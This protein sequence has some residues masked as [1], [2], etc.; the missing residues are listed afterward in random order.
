MNKGKA[1]RISARLRAGRTAHP[2][3][4]LG[5]LLVKA[6][7]VSAADRDAA[8]KIQ[9]SAH[10]VI[11]QIFIDMRACSLADISRALAAQETVP[12]ID[13]ENI[14]I[15]E[16]ALA[17]LPR[18]VCENLQ[19]LPFQKIDTL[20]C[21]A[22]TGKRHLRVRSKLQDYTDCR[23]KLYECGTGQIDEFIRRYYSL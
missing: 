3:Q 13:L 8:L 15:D 11:G 14:R 17:V 1:T 16:R 6:G 22:A 23:L 7:G 10:E 2:P 9:Q 21:V 12:H 5:E 4:S 18:E 19:V 20:L